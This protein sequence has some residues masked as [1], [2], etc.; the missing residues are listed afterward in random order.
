[1]SDDG[2][3]AER[4]T[5]YCTESAHHAGKPLF[6]WLIE[7]AFHQRLRGATARKALAGFGQHHHLHHQHLISLSDDLP[8]TVEIIDTADRIDAF[9]EQAGEALAGYTYIRENVRW[10]QPG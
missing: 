4:L 9:L 6:E 2:V 1:M 8:I 7:T 5:V 10:H 3:E